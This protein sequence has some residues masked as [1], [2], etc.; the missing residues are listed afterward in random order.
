[1]GQHIFFQNIGQREQIQTETNPI[2]LHNCIIFEIANNWSWVRW[3]MYRHKEN[4]LKE[5]DEFEK[6]WFD[7]IIQNNINIEKYEKD[8]NKFIDDYLK[9]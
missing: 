1:M 8:S 7:F 9:K 6:N 3:M 5:F 4:K 2:Y